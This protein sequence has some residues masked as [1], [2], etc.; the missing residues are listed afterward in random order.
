MK[1]RTLALVFGGIAIAFILFIISVSQRTIPQPIFEIKGETLWAITIIPGAARALGTLEIRNTLLTSWCIV[2]FVVILAFVSGRSL[3]WL[4]SG[5]QNF[6]EGIVDGIH[7][8]VVNTA[9][10]KNG[11]RFFWVIATFLIYIAISNWFALLPIFNTVGKIEPVAAEAGEFHKE[12]VVVSKTAGLS[13]IGFKTKLIDLEADYTACA[14]L[15]GEENDHCKEEANQSAID[16][17]KE[18]HHVS[19]DEKLAILAPYFRSVNTDLMTP[20]SLAIVSAIFVEYWGI[21]TL[22][23]RRYG[24]KFVNTQKLREGNLLMGTID[25]FV[26]VLEAIAELARLISFSFRLFG[27][28]LAGEILLLVMTFML[29][30]AFFVVSIFY[31]LE[32]FVGAIQA[33]VFGMLTLVFGV[34]AVS[35]HGDEHAEGEAH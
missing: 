7:G 9:G 11:R 20:L 5:W 27:N 6:I 17:A 33:F 30:F 12:A 22:G 31:G 29:P 2:A 1:A 13:V 26:G 23:L 19:G 28:M 8:L 18:K 35:G 16:E 21:S 3:K 4:P 25:V 34:L 10:E 24:S 32:I 14:G 15:N